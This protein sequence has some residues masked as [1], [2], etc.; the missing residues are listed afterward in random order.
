MFGVRFEV[1]RIS[2]PYSRVK[3]VD[4]DG[5]LIIDGFTINMAELNWLKT[6]IDDIQEKELTRLM[7]LEESQV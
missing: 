7:E 6:R 4:Q 3:L 2:S 5:E 1:L